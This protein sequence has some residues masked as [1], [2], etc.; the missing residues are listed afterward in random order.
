MASPFRRAA[1]GGRRGPRRTVA[2]ALALWLAGQVSGAGASFGESVRHRID[3]VLEALAADGDFEA[4]QSS[5][6]AEFDR[7][8]AGAE[9]EET[10]LF[11]D[12]AFS[13][14]LVRQLARAEESTRRGLLAYLRGHLGL[15]R[16]LAF[17]VGPW[18]RPEDV[19]ALLDRLRGERGGQLEPL[20]A[21]AAAVCVVH[22]RPLQRRINENVAT[23]PDPVAVF[24]YFAVNE[25]RLLFGVRTVPAELLVYVVDTTATVE[26][27]RWALERYAGD[28][29][30]GA[31]FFDVEYDREHFRDGD[32]KKVTRAGWNLPNILRY[33]G[34]C[35]D[36]AYFAAGVGKA[37]GVP[38]AY[39]VGSGSEV[40]HAWVGFLQAQRGKAWW[41]FDAGRYRE[42]QGVRGRVLDPQT[43]Q[44]VADS[45]VSLLAELALVP[46]A[47]RWAA[48]ALTDAALR[49]LELAKAGGIPPHDPEAPARRG[50]DLESVLAL[51]ERGL[52]SSAGCVAG[53]LVVR[54]LAASGRLTLDQ[55]RR[56]AGVLDRLCGER[57][58]D[59]HLEVLAPMIESIED[60][61]E[62]EVFWR[63][64]VERFAG[65][66]DLTAAI[67]EAQGRMWKRAGQLARAG[68]CYEEIVVRYANAGPFVIG[69]LREAE[70]ILRAAGEGRRVPA[71]YEKAFM[72]IR[73]P[74]DMAAPFYRQ[75]NYF[76]VGAM[77]AD[78]L[79][80]AGLGQRA[81]GIRAQIGFR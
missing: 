74:D 53:W 32:P 9:L 47:D 3:G 30:V 42:Y 29:M 13:L 18:D 69:A 58:P 5:L 24:D 28:T 71:L 73:R 16:T 72:Q 55:K 25:D 33:G 57:Y 80:E 41:N 62:Q 60:L 43:R 31:R 48:S 70:G 34:V 35:V 56:W 65:R 6:S 15:A 49:L 40:S 63:K 76:R 61:Q 4:A 68:R 20:R 50:T 38:T 12:A 46:E 26:E 23:A 51:V 66:H 52:R 10:A 78:R 8:V 44:H 45:S 21:L 17:L 11:T 81:A 67:L 77:L 14:R 37:I 39:A 7:I 75:S 19:Y 79:E 64:V 27:M 36:Q 22:D 1:A 2:G 54:D 59:F